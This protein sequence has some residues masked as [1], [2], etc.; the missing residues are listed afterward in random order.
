MEGISTKNFLFLL[1]YALELED[2]TYLAESVNN[3][4]MD[5]FDFYELLSFTL[6]KLIRKLIKKGIYKS[7]QTTSGKIKRV[8]GKILFDSIIKKGGIRSSEVEC[9]YDELTFNNLENRII[10]T[11]L[12]NIKL[13][14]RKEEPSFS[15]ARIDERRKITTEASKIY[16]LLSSE[17]SYTTLSPE[18]F[19]KV[20]YNKANKSYRPI[21]N[22]CKWLYEVKGW[23]VGNEEKGLSWN[24]QENVI[25]ERFLRNY[26]KENLKNYK[27]KAS[28]ANN[29]LDI[30][31]GRGIYFQS[32]NPDIVIYKQNEPVF[33]LDAKF[34]GKGAVRKG[35]FN[36]QIT[37]SHNLYQLISYLNFYNCDGLLV[38]AQAKNKKVKELVRINDHNYKQINP[39]NRFRFGF[40][41][42]N[43]G[44]ELEELKEELDEFVNDLK[45]EVKESCMRKSS[46]TTK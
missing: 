3:K 36:N 33:V 16:K 43:L 15:S 38:Y 23:Q 28:R 1:T 5:D 42:I 26:L 30:V 9:E 7:F 29:W 39:E 14:L 25:F 12:R 44:G 11:T 6:I 17:V 37:D 4:D 24:E 45:L 40:T 35:R 2:R 8:R 18:V 20:N 34:Y 31:E 41:N 32:I 19:K 27:V 21:I 10:L 13:K 22:I 46:F